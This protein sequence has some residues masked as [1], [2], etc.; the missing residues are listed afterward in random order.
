MEDGGQEG[1]AAAEAGE[2]EAAPLRIADFGLRIED[3]AALAAPSGSELPFSVSFNDKLA[4]MGLLKHGF[5]KTTAH[6]GYKIHGQ[7]RG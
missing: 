2:G 3:A 5:G 4:F 6:R 7:K 1:G